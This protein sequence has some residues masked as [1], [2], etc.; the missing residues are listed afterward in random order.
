MKK[1]FSLLT[2]FLCFNAVWAQ[3]TMYTVLDTETGTMTF[4]YDEN[5]PA[6]TASRR[7]YDVPTSS[8][9]PGWYSQSS[10]IKKVVI[11]TSFADARPTTCYAW[12]IG[13]NELTEIQSIGNLNTSEVKDMGFMFA[14]C[15]CLTSL[16]LS[17]FNTAKV[18]DMSYMFSYCFGLTSLNLSSFNTENVTSM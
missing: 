4:M 13:C 12:F 3:K 11:D 7:V 1:I 2:L 15:Y 6:S 17:N 18:Q 14:Y 9:D 10:N 5:K 8:S 16:D